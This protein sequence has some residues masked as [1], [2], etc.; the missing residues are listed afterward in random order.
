MLSD[1][2]L[3]AGDV[4]LRH[5]ESC[6]HAPGSPLQGIVLWALTCEVAC[7]DIIDVLR[8][9][10]KTSQ[11]RKTEE[12]SNFQRQIVTERHFAKG[13]FSEQN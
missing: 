1:L 6:G 11:R 5:D 10:H 8:Q 9:G 2:L 4:G 13:K 7:D 3:Q 12:F